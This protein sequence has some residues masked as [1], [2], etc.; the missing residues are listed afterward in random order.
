MLYEVITG[1][2]KVVNSWGTSWG[3]SGIAWVDQDYFC[4]DDFCFCAFVA[5]DSQTDP[6]TDGDNQVDDPSSGY[7]LIAW[8][9]Y[10]YD[11]YDVNNPD[12]SDNP[13]WRTSYYN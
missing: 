9:L 10:D 2:F 11:Y 5:T 1:A 7:D 13:R 6:D 8:E 12:Y 3:E 4:T